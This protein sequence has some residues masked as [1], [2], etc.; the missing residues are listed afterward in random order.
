MKLILQERAS[1]VEQMDGRVK[2][3]KDSK[4]EE[5]NEKE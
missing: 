1:V 2:D 4:T 3:L 5:K